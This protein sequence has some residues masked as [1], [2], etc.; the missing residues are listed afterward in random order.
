[1][2]PKEVV[3]PSGIKLRPK[4]TFNIT[5]KLIHANVVNWRI[6]DEQTQWNYYVFLHEMNLPA[7]MFDQLWL[8]PT[9][10]R[11]TPNSPL[12]E[13]YNYY[14]PLFNRFDFHGGI[15]FY[16]RHNYCEGC[17]AIELGCDYGHIWDREHGEYTVHEVAH[18][19]INTIES[20]LTALQ[21]YPCVK[22]TKLLSQPHAT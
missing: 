13:S 14:T 18:D 12:R 4:I 16:K 20:I 8:K 6:M 3:L 5:H 19:C 15:T 7:G 1:M 11:F 22:S 21:L 9:A 17:R 2:I 10:E